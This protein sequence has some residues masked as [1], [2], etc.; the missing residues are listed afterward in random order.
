MSHH[1]RPCSQ[2][3][4]AVF[5]LLSELRVSA[6]RPNGQPFGPDHLRFKARVCLGCALVELHAPDVHGLCASA[7]DPDA[8]VALLDVTTP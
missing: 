2:C 6:H 7:S 3:G 4:S 5:V 1:Q 8:G